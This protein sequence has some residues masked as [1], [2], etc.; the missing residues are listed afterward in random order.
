VKFGENKGASQSSA[1]L[2]R[3]NGPDGHVVPTLREK[4]IGGFGPIGQQRGEKTVR[5]RNQIAV[6]TGRK[7]HTSPGKLRENLL[8]SL[9]EAGKSDVGKKRCQETQ[10]GARSLKVGPGGDLLLS[11]PTE[12]GPAIHWC[13]KTTQGG[14]TFG[15]KRAKTLKF[16]KEN[17]W[18]DLMSSIGFG[19]RDYGKRGHAALSSR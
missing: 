3:S 13:K 11:S 17:F 19:L 8:F 2:T 6:D 7:K 4:G 14:C 18:G 9:L 15:A 12:D 10:L 5:S 16:L 1:N